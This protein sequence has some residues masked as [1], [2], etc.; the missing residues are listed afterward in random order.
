MSAASAWKWINDERDR[1][2]NDAWKWTSDAEWKAT[3]AK[4][5]EVAS[6]EFEEMRRE[7]AAVGEDTQVEHVAAAAPT[8]PSTAVEHIASSALVAN[9][10]LED[11]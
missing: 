4:D 5:H 7:A 11:A 8:L 1:N 3:L 6:K 10:S 2:A 9:F